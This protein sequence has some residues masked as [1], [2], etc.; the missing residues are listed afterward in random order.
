MSKTIY[1]HKHHIIPR[2]AGGSDD[3]S[4]L[5]ELTVEEH[6]LAHKKLFE[7]HGRWQDKI[8]WLTLSGQIGKDEAM[9]MVR[10][11][12]QKG[13]LNHRYG[14]SGTMLGKNH[15][16][17]SKKKMSESHKGKILSEEHKRKLS[18]SGKGRKQSEEH[19]R[20][21]SES[22]KGRVPWNKGKKIGPHTEERKR[23]NSESNKGKVPWNK[24]MK[25]TDETKRKCS[26]AKKEWWR[27][28][29]EKETQ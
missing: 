20:K 4:N 21:N 13:V 12:G 24:G 27:L 8:A 11:E 15:T 3:P 28:K 18:E 22:N 17:E 2:H 5:I 25:A 10:S 29:K 1:T 26:E 23:K 16:E 7:E 6:A 19:K 14:K 9:R